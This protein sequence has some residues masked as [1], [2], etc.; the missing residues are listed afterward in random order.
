MPE[1]QTGNNLKSNFQFKSEKV[2]WEKFEIANKK[3]QT[4][5]GKSKP[6]ISTKTQKSRQIAEISAIMISNQP[7]SVILDTV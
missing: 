5:A 6:L 1:K 4:A 7:D 3:I 2:C